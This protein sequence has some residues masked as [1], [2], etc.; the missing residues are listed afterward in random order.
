KAKNCTIEAARIIKEAAEKAGLPENIIAWI[1]EPSLDI[2]AVIMK[3]VDLILATGG[4]GM[5]HAAYSSGTPAVGVGPGNCNVIFDETCDIK[6]AVA[7]TIHSKTFDNGMIC[8]SE[9][10]ITAVDSIYNAVKKEFQNSRC[11]FLNADEA[12]KVGELFFNPVTHGVNPAIVGRP[13]VTIAEMAGVTVPA[14]TKVL[15]A[16]TDDT[17]H[18]NAWA[19]EKLS[20]LL[21]MFRA[22]DFET[23]LDICDKLV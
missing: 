3:E 8:A 19:N 18:S 13:A 7:S 21:G 2:T 9:Q 10:S 17:S 12:K 16:E 20:P 15:I 4:P 14:D 22:K 5:V 23:A 6:N 1:D 11:Y